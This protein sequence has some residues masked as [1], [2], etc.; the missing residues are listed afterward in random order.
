M[1]SSPKIEDVVQKIWNSPRKEETIILGDSS[2]EDYPVQPPIK[3]IEVVFLDSSESVQPSQPS[4][5][6]EPSHSNLPDVQPSQPNSPNEPNDQADTP[7]IPETNAPDINN[8]MTD[9]EH[10]PTSVSPAKSSISSIHAQD[11]YNPDEY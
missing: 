5:P 9:E 1:K 10:V 4:L 3:N 2:T 6:D 11:F 7:I 8:A